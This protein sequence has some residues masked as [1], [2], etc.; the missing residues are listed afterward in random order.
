MN[1]YGILLGFALM[2]RVA[3]LHAASGVQLYQ[4]YA[5]FVSVHSHLSQPLSDPRA[6]L[7]DFLHLSSGSSLTCAWTTEHDGL[8]LHEGL[9]LLSATRINASDAEVSIRD[10]AG[11]G[12]GII[13]PEDQ[14]L[15]QGFTLPTVVFPHTL[16]M[17]YLN[18]SCSPVVAH[19]LMPNSGI[20]DRPTLVIGFRAAAA[21]VR[22]HGRQSTSNSTRQ[23]QR[24]NPQLPASD[25]RINT[26]LVCELLPPAA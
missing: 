14:S 24:I 26:I 10:D 17:F 15:V 19:P 25:L 12:A 18:D 13:S 2:L 1:L 23:T 22:L 5:K 3:P 9:G 8:Q 20:V 16:A 6:A 7:R 21:S 4:R 11:T